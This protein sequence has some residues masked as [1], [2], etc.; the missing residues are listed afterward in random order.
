MSNAPLYKLIFCNC[1]S[2]ATANEIANKLVSDRIA[3]CVNI[4]PGLRSIYL[5][6][7]QLCNE[8]EYLLLIKTTAANYSAV[9]TSILATHPYELPEIIA[10]PINADLPA[11]LNW[12]T[13][14]LKDPA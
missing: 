11:Y 3:A 10:V 7:G 13:T 12:M 5:W 1:P 4:L 9:E 2:E 6:E 8:S 14:T